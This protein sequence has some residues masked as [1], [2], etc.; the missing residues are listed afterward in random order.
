[1]DAMVN[2]GTAFL[3]LARARRNAAHLHLLFY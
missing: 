2:L 3:S 1:M